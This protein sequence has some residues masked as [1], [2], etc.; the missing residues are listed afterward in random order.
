VTLWPA[1]AFGSEINMRKY[2]HPWTSPLVFS[3]NEPNTLYYGAQ[4]VMKTTDGGLNWKEISPDLTGDTRRNGEPAP[5]DSTSVE[6]AKARGYGTVYSIAPSPMKAGQIWAGTDTGLIH[7]TRDGGKT[8]INVTPPG[9]ADWSKITLIEPS[10]FDP[11]T[12]YAAVDR[13]RLE[14]YKPYLYRTRDFGKSWTLVA[15]GIEEPAFLNAVREDP[16]RK[17]LLFAG[18][19]LGVYVSFDDGDHW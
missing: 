2:R 8:W 3:P 5:S 19:E 4:Y 1:P 7:L 15:N 9:L 16:A 13:H 10:H 17:G 14:D 6:N 11:G 18:T 12:A